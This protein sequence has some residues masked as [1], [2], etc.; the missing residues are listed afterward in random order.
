VIGN[1]LLG[2]APP[3]FALLYWN[4]D[5]TRVPARVHSTLLRELFL[6]NK[7]QEPG[8]L[9]VLGEGIDLRKVK[10]PTYAVAAQGDHIVP[11]Q[12]VFKIRELMG[13][14]VR[15]VLTEGGHIAGVVN[16]P[17][18][19]KKRGYYAN[20]NS[21]TADPEAWLAGAEK[22]LDSWWTD[23]VPWLE[24]QSGELVDPPSMGSG[25]YPPLMDAPGTYVLEK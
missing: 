11:W 10:T 6:H 24:G 15:L 21:D 1:Y 8:K 22:T 9:V 25:A 4:S 12:G 18:P 13:G 5:A 2:Q 17:T 7:L 19:E 3:A 23:W 16:P 14:P 20:E